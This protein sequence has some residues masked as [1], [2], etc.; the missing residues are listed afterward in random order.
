MPAILRADPFGLSPGALA[1]HHA[2]FA[3][4]GGRGVASVR[5]VVCR[6]HARRESSALALLVFAREG[7]LGFFTSSETGRQTNFNSALRIRTP[8]SI[9]ASVS[10]WKPLQMPSTERPFSAF[11]FTS[12]M[13]GDCAAIAPQRR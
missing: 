5:G 1:E 11:V 7:G 3:F 2:T 9:P 10:T 4:E 12:R 6:R 13:I 8:G